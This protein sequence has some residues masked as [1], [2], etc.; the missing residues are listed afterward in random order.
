MQGQPGGYR[1]ISIFYTPHL[2]LKATSNGQKI[3]NLKIRNG[4]LAAKLSCA[5]FLVFVDLVAF[6]A[7]LKQF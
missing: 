3:L 7:A 5:A 1:R 6:Q 4:T 2:P